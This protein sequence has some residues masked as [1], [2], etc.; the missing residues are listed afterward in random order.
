MRFPMTA[1][2]VPILLSTSS[3]LLTHPSIDD[4]DACYP[5][6]QDDF[7][8]TK[9]AVS[10]PRACVHQATVRS[11]ADTMDASRMRQ[12]LDYLTGFRTRHWSSTLG[13]RASDWL[14]SHI[15]DMIDTAS[16]PR[17]SAFVYG[18]SHPWRQ[19]SI[20]ATI[21]G[22]TDN[23]V[24]IS[25]HLDS[26]N[27]IL[28]RLLSAPG[29]D[30]DGSGVVTILEAL[31][32]LLR[33]EH[34]NGGNARNTIEFHW[35]SAEEA[36]MLGSAAIFKT[37]RMLGRRVKAMLQQDMTG[38]IQRTVDAGEPE[39]IGVVVDYVHPGLTRFVKTVIDEYCNIPWV[40]TRCGYPCSDHV[41]ALENGF[42][43]AFALESAVEYKNPYIHTPYDVVHY[44]SFEHMLEHA[45]LTLGFAYELAWYDFEKNK[46]SE[47][48]RREHVPH[49]PQFEHPTASHAK[50][51]KKRRGPYPIEPI[52]AFYLFLAANT[53]AAMWAPIQDCDETFNYWEPTHYLSN[54]YGLQT[55]EY[56]PDYAIRSW[57]YVALHA[58]VGS[59]RRLLPRSTKVSEFYFVRFTLAFICALCQTV[60]FKA[61]CTSL[62]ARVAIFF[63]IAT[64]SSPG[65]FHASA[66]FL[67]SSFAMYMVMLGAACFMNWLGGLKT[68]RGIFWFA[69]AGILGWPFAAALCVPFIIEEV[70]FAVFSGGEA[71]FEA[72]VRLFRGAVAGLIVLLVDFL[73]N[74]FFYRRMTVVTWNIIKYN[75]LSSAGGPELYGTE[76]WHFYLRNLA[77]NFNIWFALAL[78]ALPIFFLQKVLSTSGHGFQSGLRT[79]VFVAPFYMWLAIFT[80]QPHK[81]ERF[82]YPLYPFLALNASISL[83]ML[84]SAMGRASSGTLMGKIPGRLK[85]LGAGLVL[86]LSLC[87]GLARSYGVYSA[88]SAPMRVYEPLWGDDAVGGPEDLVCFGKEWYR[89]PSSYF[90]PR[91]MHAKF[92]RS[93]FRGLLPGEFAEART[94]FGSWGGTWLPT[95]GLN[96]GNVEDASKYVE[97][98]ACSLLVDT[99]YPERT[100]EPPPPPPDEPDY[101]A[102]DETWETIRCEPFLDAASTHL[103]ARALWM[104][105][106]GAVPHRLR[107]RWGRLYGGEL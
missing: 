7:Y 13:R 78:L 30:D 84:L 29:A 64:V 3:S 38:Y 23:T 41:S 93:A 53:V 4:D 18:I 98:R 104:P 2:V 74:L 80:A 9:A 89:F 76:P 73:V 54:G 97:L 49:H 66:A 26:V 35:Y 96:D 11:L 62:N 63:L 20:I 67:P 16:L 79:V 100:E 82:M 55:W 94:G 88:Y 50:K 15:S 102:D 106:L 68:S 27:S 107:R 12:R 86:L 25:A 57:L 44:L 75:I 101:V 47:G 99:Q 61:I 87:L 71:A 43:S 24:I 1:A 34:I 32:A 58:V 8:G 95:S 28:P 105:D 46:S 19:Q 48:K 69:V 22:L 14:L 31:Q 21:P 45:R 5:P 42:P 17:P 92:I 70:V 91:D 6:G 51:K 90:L 59:V 40:E 36:Q 77:L 33:D 72:A 85:L 52:T 60:F 81:E 103:V 83:H 10:Y 37:Y 39:S 65:N 56:S